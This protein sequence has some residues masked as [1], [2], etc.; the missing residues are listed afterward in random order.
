MAVLDSEAEREF[1][2]FVR[3]E[4]PAL[5]RAAYLMTGDSHHAQDLVQSTLA[6]VA[7]H[8]R[9]AAAH[10]QAYTR[11]SLYHQAVSWWRWRGRRPETPFAA[12]PEA[13]P[14]EA[15]DRERR[16]VVRAAARP[17]DAQTAR[18]LGAAVFRGSLRVGD[19]PVARMLDRHGEKPNPP[20]AWATARAGA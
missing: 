9:A 20:R 3:V 6:N 2:E 12:L 16:L 7:L 11:K 8:W 17:A 14:D 18:G 10:P 19:G 13:T 4:T 1:R 5:M 15:D